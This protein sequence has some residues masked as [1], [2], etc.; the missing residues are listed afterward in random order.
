MVGP[1]PVVSVVEVGPVIDDVL[2]AVLGFVELGKEEIARIPTIAARSTPTVT[3][4]P[5][6]FLYSDKSSHISP[7]IGKLTIHCYVLEGYFSSLLMCSNISS[8]H[9]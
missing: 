3:I 4:V 7:S 1:G 9:E 5:I 8:A 6:S 2:V